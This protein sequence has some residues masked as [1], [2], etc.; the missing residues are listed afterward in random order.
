MFEKIEGQIIYKSN[1]FAFV[2]NEFDLKQIYLNKIINF[3]LYKKYKFY[4]FVYRLIGNKNIEKEIN[5]G[6]D[7][8]NDAI[9][10]EDL[11]NIDGVGIK[12]ALKIIKNGYKEFMN[13]ILQKDL[14]QITKQ[15]SL[16]NNI[17][18]N[19]LN[20]FN[21]KEMNNYT[22]QELKKINA[23][24]DN[25]QK[26]GYTKQLSTKVV[27]KRKDQIISDQFVN[28]FNTLIEDIKNE[29]INN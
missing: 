12:S 13:L 19:I 26:L 8:L 10:F 14:Y 24:I 29:R 2:E 15:Y 25:L 20:Y 7:N 28:V 21:K 3:E 4:I 11:I 9:C 22:T 16:S 5:F 6:F 17:A 1:S 27:W 18:T 23:A